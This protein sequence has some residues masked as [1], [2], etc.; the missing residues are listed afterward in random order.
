RD[1]SSDVCS[2]D[3]R[4]SAGRP[5]GRPADVDD[6]GDDG[7]L[8]RALCA[9]VGVQGRRGE[10]ASTTVSNCHASPFGTIFYGQPGEAPSNSTTKRY[11]LFSEK[12]GAARVTTPCASQRSTEPPPTGSRTGSS[13]RRA[14]S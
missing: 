13:A 2:S 8:R 7:D 1:W 4:A 10:G 14:A 11:W 12:I 9:R 5:V 6:A 3:L